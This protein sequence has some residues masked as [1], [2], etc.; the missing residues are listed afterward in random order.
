MLLLRL[1]LVTLVAYLIGSIPTGVLLA[2][3]FDWPDPRQNGSGHTGALNTFRSTGWKAAALVLIL[4]MAKGLAA[5]LVARPIAGSEWALPLAGMAATAGHAWPLWLAFNGGMGLATGAGA[6]AAANPLIVLLA[7]ALLGVARAFINHTPRAVVAS[8]LVL[9][10]V[11]L[12]LEVRPPVFWLATGTALV[13]ALRHLS[14]WDR[15]YGDSQT[16]QPSGDVIP[17]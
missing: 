15:E 5:A 2:R 6:V 14:D 9:P 3:A 7:L 10:P 16:V 4:D 12:A 17:D 13:I 1:V 11:L 8:M